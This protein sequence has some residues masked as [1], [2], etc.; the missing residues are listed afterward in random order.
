M[1]TIHEAV[2]SGAVDEVAR[3]IR[4]SPDMVNAPNQHGTTP[5]HLAVACAGADMVS[6]LLAHGADTSAVAKG[7]GTP[8]EEAETFLATARESVAATPDT[9]RECEQILR[10]L[11]TVSGTVFIA[12]RF[13]H[14]IEKGYRTQDDYEL[15]YCQ[16]CGIKAY[17]HPASSAWAR[18]ACADCL[19]LN[20]FGR[21]LKTCAKHGDYAVFLTETGRILGDCS[22]CHKEA[23]EAALREEWRRAHKCEICGTKLS[24]FARMR[25]DLRCSEHK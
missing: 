11:N 21:A 6:L 17:A 2:P 3:I 12:E 7:C 18:R 1:A 22:R 15:F 13:H 4:E 10:L 14:R 20:V 9:V 23:Q 25:G 5:L 8:L 19:N 16:W 24:I